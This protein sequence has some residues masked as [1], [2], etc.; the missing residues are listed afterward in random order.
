MPNMLKKELLEYE[1]P[2]VNLDEYLV[3]CAKS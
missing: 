2:E 3:I 1:K